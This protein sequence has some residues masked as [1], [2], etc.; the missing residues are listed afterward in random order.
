MDLQTHMHQFSHQASA[1]RKPFSKHWFRV[2]LTH[3]LAYM[4]VSY[5]ISGA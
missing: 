3:T 4:V 1:D 5:R 2:L